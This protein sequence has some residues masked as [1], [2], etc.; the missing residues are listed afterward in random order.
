MRAGD[1]QVKIIERYMRE[2]EIPVADER[3]EV[4]G[5]LQFRGVGGLVNEPDAVGHR[6]VS[7]RSP[8]L[9]AL[10]CQSIK[11]PHGLAIQIT[12][13]ICLDAIRRHP[14]Q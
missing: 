6:Q 2:H 14:E 5:R 4:F 11:E 9:L 7:R 12:E 8:A 3:P 13:R 10:T 1:K